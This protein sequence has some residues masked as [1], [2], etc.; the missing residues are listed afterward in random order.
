MKYFWQVKKSRTKKKK[1]GFPL[2]RI[3]LIFLVISIIAFTSCSIE[4]LRIS[5]DSGD[6]DPS[7]PV[8]E[9]HY[10]YP[11][12]NEVTLEWDAN[13]EP[14]IAGY[15]VYYGYETGNYLYSIDVGN[16]TSVTL[17]DL[18]PGQ[19]YCFAATAYNTEGYESDFSKEIA[20]TLP[21]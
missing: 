14:D 20:Y 18:E 17:E 13:T 3:F 11:Q 1:P 21:N 10:E 7:K 19:T 16:H 12:Q 9:Y 4:P 2:S 15:I 5:F 6:D 8:P